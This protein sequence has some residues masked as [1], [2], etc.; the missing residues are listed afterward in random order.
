[1]KQHCRTRIRQR[2]IHGSWHVPS[3]GKNPPQLGR[4]HTSLLLGLIFVFVMALPSY[5]QNMGIDYMDDNTG[6][7]W[8][9]ISNVTANWNFV[10]LNGCFTGTVNGNRVERAFSGLTLGQS[11][12]ISAQIQDDVLGQILPSGTVVFENGGSPTCSDGIQNQG[13]TG[14]DCGGPCPACSSDPTCSDGIQNQGETGVDCGGPCQACPTG[15][16]VEAE[17]GSVLG[18]ARVYDDPA[19]SGGQGFAYLDEVGNGFSLD[20]T[21]SAQ[22]IEVIY[23]SQNT[24]TISILVNGADGG[25]ITFNSTN[26]WVENYST[27]SHTVS[28]PANSSI[29]IINQSGDVAMNVDYINFIGI[30]AD[31]TCTDGIKNGNE[32]GI[33]CGGPDCEPCP[34]TEAVVR[35]S[36]SNGSELLVGGPGSVSNG[37][38]L[39]T[40]D[41]DGADGISDCEGGCVETWPPL[42]VNSISEAIIP[43]LTGFNGTFGVSGRCDGTLQL[44]YNSEPLYFYN[45]DNNEGDTNGD[46]INGTWHVVGGDSP[47]PTCD[48]GIQNGSET[49]IDC[50]GPD[51]PACDPCNVD[52]GSD[53]VGDD[54]V[55]GLNSEGVAY[56]EGVSHSPSFFIISLDGAGAPGGVTIGKNGRREADFS[57]TVVAG[58][59]YTLEVRIQGDNYGTG[60]CIHSIQ[61]QAGEG[62]DSTPCQTG[63]G[64]G[65]GVVDLPD[66]VLAVSSNASLGAFLTGSSG[67]DKPGYSLY[68]TSGTCTGACLDTWQPLL[69]EDQELINNPGGI[70]NSVGSV[71]YG[72]VDC[73][74]VWQATLDGS[75]LYFYSGD[76]SPGQSNG[77]NV[78]PWSIAAVN[79][80]P[81][82]PNQEYMRSALKTPINGRTPGAFGWVHDITGRQVQVRAGDAAVLQWAQS[83]FVD[84]VGSVYDGPGDHDWTLVCS[85]NQ[86]EFYEAEM[87]DAS[88][89][90]MEVQIPGNCFD[91]FYYFFR[92]KKAGLPSDDLGTQMVYSGLFEYDERNPNDR[93]DPASQP[94]ITSKSANW[95]R[96]RH[97]RAHDGNTELI[98]NSQNNFGA[99]RALD[100]YTTTVTTGGS[101]TTINAALPNILRIEALDNGLIRNANP[102]YVYNKNVCCGTDM[103]YGNVITYEITIGA[104]ASISSQIYNTFQ[105][106]IV[107]KGFES[108]IGDPRLTLAGRAS[109]TMEFSTSG[110]H[111]DL[112]QDA[113]FTQ[114]LTTLTTTEDVDNFLEG[115]H[116]FHGLTDQFDVVQARPNFGSV[117]IGSQSC[118]NCH[119]RDGRGSEVFNTPD[120]PRLPPPVFG[121]GILQYIEGADAG[122][123]WD[124]DVPTV[125]QQTRNALVIDHGVD[126]D[127]ALSPEDLNRLVKYVEHLTVPNRNAA[128]YLDNDV[129]EGHM[130]FIE[131]GCT[132]CH[133]ETAKTT[134]SAPPEFRDLYLRP[135]TDMKIH[136]VNGGNFRTSPLWG[137]GRNI[138]LLERN[139][140][141]LLFMHNGSA[142]T[143]DGAIQDHSGDASSIR[144]AYNA[145]SPT[146]KAQLIKFLETL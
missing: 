86:K 68:I 96:F 101:S 134:S 138:D 123:T 41:D 3:D 27:V 76:S 57:G 139:G 105:H 59:T 135:Y 95:M 6:L 81:K 102:A 32:T 29:D 26:S 25:N 92:Y 124:G 143:L 39:Y 131:V 74:P 66:P 28:I 54:F 5:S 45:G 55:M 23:A 33:D 8:F 115:H 114:H 136:N 53:V 43:T 4:G 48:D 122:L 90:V 16:K 2:S 10:C 14:V 17:S 113:I 31:P 99:V 100:R 97:P 120:G 1:M 89:G 142:S 42:L 30:P 75:G 125:E 106:I 85:C 24:G 84:G 67:T 18:T 22:T 109:T 15:T 118:Q 119:F 12:E 65:P 70:T 9:D 51:C 117:L 128:A 35:A 116:I 56:H 69:V 141:A 11:Y 140:K 37:L 132:N 64:G 129:V 77:H 127:T 137:L 73:T 40:W 104:G 111:V 110:S 44:T 94:Q 146:E 63:G 80:L 87:T 71:S 107:G 19:A 121:T 58:Q 82:L 7:V 36:T 126:P 62:A 112:E 79:R 88:K 108:S 46:G 47:P 78:G 60:Q 13:E 133:A 98:F 144:S 52:P 72:E 20:G 130:K 93:I 21:P 38:T 91:K 83:H 49:G 50:G 103:D 145:L 61:V 34:N